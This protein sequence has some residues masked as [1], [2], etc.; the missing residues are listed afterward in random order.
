MKEKREQALKIGTIEKKKK[1]PFSRI[2][3][4]VSSSN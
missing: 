4:I 2:P 3:P 1:K